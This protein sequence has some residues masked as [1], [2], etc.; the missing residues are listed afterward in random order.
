MGYVLH[1]CL[2]IFSYLDLYEVHPSTF[3]PY[4][5][6]TTCIEYNVIILCVCTSMRVTV[7]LINTTVCMVVHSGLSKHNSLNKVNTAATDDYKEHFDLYSCSYCTTNQ[8]IHARMSETLYL[9]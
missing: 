3:C 1:D 6:Y 8:V 5:N 4:E 7:D 2:S 9:D